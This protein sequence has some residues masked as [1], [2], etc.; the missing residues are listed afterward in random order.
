MQ[1]TVPLEE[2]SMF[3]SPVQTY[4]RVPSTIGAALIPRLESGGPTASC[5]CAAG[6]RTPAVARADD[7]LRLAF[8]DRDDRR[9][10]RRVD[11]QAAGR[12]VQ[13]SSPVF[14]SNAKTR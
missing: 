12:L 9:L 10:V 6:S 7:E 14:L 3:T 1:R 4:T 11:R 13:F 5:P 8:D 2:L